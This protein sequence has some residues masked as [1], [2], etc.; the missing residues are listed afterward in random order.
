MYYYDGDFRI[1]EEPFTVVK[2]YLRGKPFKF[3]FEFKN[4]DITLK[5]QDKIKKFC[6]EMDRKVLSWSP[7]HRLPPR[8]PNEWSAGRHSE[9][10]FP[11]PNVRHQ[12]QL[13]DADTQ[14]PTKGARAKNFEQVC[15]RP[16]R[17]AK[18]ADRHD[19]NMMTAAEACSITEKT[20][21]LDTKRHLRH[22]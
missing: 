16:S 17:V 9:S 18:F 15:R 20:T 8:S 7:G 13:V 6:S 19:Q 14:H 3:V 1:G 5:N 11:R 2:P 22:P 10:S 4:R 12:T 21:E